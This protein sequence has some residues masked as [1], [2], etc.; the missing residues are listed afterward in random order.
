LYKR[1]QTKNKTV[2]NDV[3]LLA[4]RLYISSA[5]FKTPDKAFAHLNSA[6]LHHPPP[7][8]KKPRHTLSLK[9]IPLGNNSI[10]HGPK[11]PAAANESYCN[12][13]DL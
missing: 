2:Q 3:P 10:T 4:G 11:Q 9:I 6:M 12:Y 5:H 7:P 8:K 13:Q 1:K